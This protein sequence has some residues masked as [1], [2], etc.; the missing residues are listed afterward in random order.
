MSRKHANTIIPEAVRWF[1]RFRKKGPTA[2]SPEEA[3]NWARWSAEPANLAEFRRT[4]QIWRRL[5]TLAQIP[6]PTQQDLEAD[7][8]DPS[9]SV[10]EWLARHRRKKSS[11]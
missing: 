4:K 9:H 7:D 5:Q 11:R 10:A 6:R 2:L 1:D 3:S 8:Y